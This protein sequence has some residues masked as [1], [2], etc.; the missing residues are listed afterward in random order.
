MFCV[1][2][3]KRKVIVGVDKMLHSERQYK[4]IYTTEGPGEFRRHS[5]RNNGEEREEGKRGKWQ[6][7]RKKNNQEW[8][9]LEQ[10]EG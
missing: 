9:C 10:W 2:K 4:D 6:N 3:D 1:S 5:M 8:P 7:K